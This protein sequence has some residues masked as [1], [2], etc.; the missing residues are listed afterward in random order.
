MAKVNSGIIRYFG[1][2]QP[3]TWCRSISQERRGEAPSTSGIKVW[4]LIVEV[5]TVRGPRSRTR[6]EQDDEISGIIITLTESTA[7]GLEIS[8]ADHAGCRRPGG[9]PLRWRI[10]SPRGGRKGKWKR[11]DRRRQARGRCPSETWW[12]GASRIT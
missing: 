10:G 2:Y 4:P 12:P 11:G 7:G 1:P 3:A 5:K 8:R 9:C 6:I